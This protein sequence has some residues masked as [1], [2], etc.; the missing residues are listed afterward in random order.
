MGSLEIMPSPRSLNELLAYKLEQGSVSKGSA[1]KLLD[2]ISSESQF[3]VAT[4]ELLQDVVA[5]CSSHLP[6]QVLELLEIATDKADRCDPDS[7]S[8]VHVLLAQ[9]CASRKFDSDY[10]QI[11][12]K[13]SLQIPPRLAQ[14][15]GEQVVKTKRNVVINSLSVISSYFSNLARIRAREHSYKDAAISAAL[16]VNLDPTPTTEKYRVWVLLELVA[17][18]SPP[19]KTP[20]SVSSMRSHPLAPCDLVS[21]YARHFERYNL[22]TW[23]KLNELIRVNSDKFAR[24]NLLELVNESRLKYALLL[25]GSLMKHISVVPLERITAKLGIVANELK[26]RGLTDFCSIETVNNQECL[27]PLDSQ[28]R[29]D[30]IALDLLEM[31]ASFVNRSQ[32]ALR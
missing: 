31:T 5:G 22:V 13:P 28:M 4:F 25:I 23:G 6:V 3:S 18:G 7:L 21:A 24:W 1:Y 27:K 9:F 10:L 12:M 2:L 8:A 26:S 29:K 15:N 14:D 30:I 20:T 19:A 32:S 16:V 11:F 17:Y